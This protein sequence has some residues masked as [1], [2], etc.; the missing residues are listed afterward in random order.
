MIINKGAIDEWY[1][2]VI[3]RNVQVV[4]VVSWN[5]ATNFDKDYK[6]KRRENWLHLVS[7]FYLNYCV[8]DKIKLKL[9]CNLN[10]KKNIRNYSV[11]N[12]SNKKS[13]RQKYRHSNRVS[14]LM[15]ISH[16]PKTIAKFSKRK[17]CINNKNWRNRNLRTNEIFFIILVE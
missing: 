6:T 13:H 3:D 4:F 17:I 7:K 5:K 16:K 9:N 8:V 1:V 11:K 15:S 10:Y 12:Q 2:V 14:M